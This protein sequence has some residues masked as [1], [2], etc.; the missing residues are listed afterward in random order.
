MIRPFGLRDLRAVRALQPGGVW[1]DLFHHL[2][3]RRSALAT[4]LIAPVPWVGT[5][6]ASYVWEQEGTVAGFIQMLRRPG[7]QEAD[8]LF[9][10]P[11][12]T[13]Q[14]LGV[15]VWTELISYCILDA[16]QHDIRRLYASLPV[17]SADGDLLAALGFATYSN[18]DVLVLSRPTRWPDL[19]QNAGLRPRRAEDV[20]WLRRLYSI[21]TPLPVQHSEGLSDGD[22][23]T[24][25]SLAWWELADQQ[26]Y[27]LDEAGE[28]QGGVQMVSGRGGHWLL[29]HGDP[30]NGPLMT[31]LVH[32][33]LHVVAGKRQPVYCAVRDYQGGL[34]ATLQD[35]GFEPLE[36]RARMVK[37]LAVRVKA[38]EAVAVPGMAVERPG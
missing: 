24:A 23:P 26:G 30:G 8:V 27:I 38:A 17:D 32:Q 9:L 5:G 10:A 22:G 16:G 18:E 34:R 31:A 21:Y 11:Q 28:I 3:L 35:A 4:A 36:R 1:L 33:G 13:V 37:H 15:T 7:R 19:P 14:P 29:L 2:L 6:L 20:W 12:A 25:L